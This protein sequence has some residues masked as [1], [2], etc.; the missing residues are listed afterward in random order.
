MS[1]AKTGEERIVEGYLVRMHG[2][3]WGLALGMLCALGLFIATNVL[4]LRGGEHVGTHL[5][6][7]ANYFPGYDVAFFP[8]SFIGAIYAF[9]LGYAVGRIICAA[10]N[11]VA[12]R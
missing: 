10:Y 2:R 12:S 11:L 4:V 5:G 3:A 7:L 8:G 1:S 9:I 6:L